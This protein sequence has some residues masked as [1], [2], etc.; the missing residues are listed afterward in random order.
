M[1]LKLSEIVS[2]SGVPGLHKIVKSDSKNVIIECLDETKKRQLVRGNMMVS[3]L[4]DIS[5]YVE[6]DESQDL[7]TILQNIKA[8]YNNELP[9]N[10]KSTNAELMS[11]LEA[12]LPNYSREKVY[13][14]NVK[15]LVQWYNIL[16]MNEVSFEKEEEV[17][18]E[19]ESETEA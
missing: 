19:E 9:V 8:K 14:S 4:S 2:I 12:V 13:A 3:K 17:A 16:A 6:G 1:A 7:N 11:F 15:K 10:P 5:M 18:A